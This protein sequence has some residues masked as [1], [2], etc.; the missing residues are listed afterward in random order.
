MSMVIWNPLDRLI[1]EFGGKRK[2]SLSNRTFLPLTDVKETEDEVIIE[3]NLPGIAKEELK[4]EA[5][6]KGV[7]IKAEVN[8]K[9]ERKEK[10][11]I[12]YKE[13]FAR[14]YFRRIGFPVPVE[15]SEAKTIFKDGV[16]TLHFPKTEQYKPIQLIPEEN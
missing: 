4:I 1:E 9:E 8:G 5:T 2:A 15:S 3:T 12:I 13:R 14:K 6:P 7:T 11:K 10:G 16:L